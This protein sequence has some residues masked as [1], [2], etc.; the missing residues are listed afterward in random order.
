MECP[1]QNRDTA[2][3][4][5]DYC[6]R[7]L[8]R[9]L[10]VQM[11]RHVE[12]CPSCQQ[13]MSAQRTVWEALDEWEPAPV[14]PDF[15]ARLFARLEEDRPSWWRRL[16]EA[17]QLLWKPAMGMAAACAVLVTVSVLRTPDPTEVGTGTP[18]MAQQEAQQEAEQLDKT[19]S[20]MEMLQALEG[21]LAGEETSSS[22]SL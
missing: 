20:D 21:P 18:A 15:N 1:V 11:D 17:P 6:D 22:K 2:S 16:I 13:M 9:D 4:L 10:M 7:K 19:L 8:D 5:L 14:T 12:H 3:L